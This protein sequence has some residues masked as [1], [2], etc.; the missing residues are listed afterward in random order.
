M[1]SIILYILLN[2][3][4]VGGDLQDQNSTTTQETSETAT[5]TS[6]SADQNMM[7]TGQGSWDDR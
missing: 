5:N 4:L 3:G 2:V 1:N 6:A 7:G